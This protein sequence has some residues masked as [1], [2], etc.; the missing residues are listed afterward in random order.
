MNRG[1]R[2]RGSKR[3]DKV[4]GKDV[5]VTKFINVAAAY[6]FSE[7]NRMYDDLKNRY[8]TAAEYLKDNVDV[9]KWARCY[10]TGSRY[11]IMTTN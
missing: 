11:N 8:P 10:F 4:K 7:F 6:T 1:A 9:R 2:G 5:V 3:N